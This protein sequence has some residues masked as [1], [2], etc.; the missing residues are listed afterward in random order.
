M[1]YHRMRNGSLHENMLPGETP[2]LTL[3]GC[4]LC[5]SYIIS[6]ARICWDGIP[7]RYLK[8]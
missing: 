1:G 3:M 4:A 7:L 5:M 8:K 6:L 2:I